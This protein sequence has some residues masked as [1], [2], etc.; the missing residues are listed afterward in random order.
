MNFTYETI[1]FWKL[2]FIVMTC[3]TCNSTCGGHESVPTLTEVTIKGL[4]TRAAAK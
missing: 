4:Q 3:I 1:T 2:D